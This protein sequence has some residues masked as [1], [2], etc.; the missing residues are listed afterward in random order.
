M[1]RILILTK[2]TLA[3]QDL[4]CSLQRSNSDVYCSSRLLH[5]AGACSD[6][7]RHFSVVIFS[8][9][10]PTLEFS[11]YLFRFKK[12]GVGILRKGDKEAIEASE[13]SEIIEVV[14]EWINDETT[15]YELI[16]KIAKVE[17][18][19][20]ASRHEKMIDYEAF[21]NDAY[22]NLIHGLSNNE[23][24]FLLYMYNAEN[25]VVSREQ[26]CKALW[27]GANTHSTLSQLSSL[28][29]RLKLKISEA[30]FDQEELKTIWGKGYKLENKLYTFLKDNDFSMEA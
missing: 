7:I 3:E 18:A 20:M 22:S 14:D 19:I 5:E 21:P 13:F 16:E 4:Q 29:Q 23:K 28:L 15:S 8:D 2:N 12:R 9:T 10:I 17:S 26:L 30:G 6:I 27:K 11:K 1:A 25:K 24:K